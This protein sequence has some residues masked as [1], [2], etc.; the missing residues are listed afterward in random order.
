[1]MAPAKGGIPAST[2]IY[3][4]APGGRTM[5]ETAVYFSQDGKPI[6]RTNY[7]NRVR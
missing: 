5:I 2:R 3:T 1:M 6:M 7:F 4:V